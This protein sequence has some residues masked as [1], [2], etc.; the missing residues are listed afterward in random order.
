MYCNLLDSPSSLFFTKFLFYTNIVYEF[1]ILHHLK[2]YEFFDKLLL[3]GG[4]IVCDGVVHTMSHQWSYML[5]CGKWGSFV[6]CCVYGYVWGSDITCWRII[7]WT[8]DTLFI[9]GCGRFF[10]GTAE[11]M[12]HAL[13]EVLVSLPADTVGL[14]CFDNSWCYFCSTASL[15]W[16]WVYC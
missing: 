14:S 16:S 12:F 3:L 11:Q 6:T 9:G 7:G 13:C 4:T 2:Y 15:L 8:G 10:E 5:L 1:D